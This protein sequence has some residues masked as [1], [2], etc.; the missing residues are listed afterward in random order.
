MAGLLYT[1]T[2]A[3]I[4]RGLSSKYFSTSIV[5]RAVHTWVATNLSHEGEFGRCRFQRCFPRCAC[6]APM[7]SAI[8]AVTKLLILT[9]SFSA[10]AVSFE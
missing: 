5:I 2:Q 1:R 3:A 6:L 7:A 9:P 8:I 4:K 10:C